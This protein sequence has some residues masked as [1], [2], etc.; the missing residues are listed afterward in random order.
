MNM[1]NRILNIEA[2]EVARYIINRGINNNEPISNL[3]LQKILY[4]VQ[5]R[6]IKKFK[7]PLFEDDFEAWYYGPVIPKVYHRYSYNSSYAILQKQEEGE[8]YLSEEHLEFIN[9]I[10]DE[11]IKVDAWSLVDKSHIK[12]GAWDIVY[13]QFDSP[14]DIIPKEILYLS[15]NE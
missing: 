15:E 12:D 5:S 7:K 3:Q 1:D 10:I 11:L 4:F 2:I 9:N 13:N 6:F 8:M 14:S